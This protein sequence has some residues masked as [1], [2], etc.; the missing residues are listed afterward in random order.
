MFTVLSATRNKQL[1]ALDVSGLVI[2]ILLTPYRAIHL[3]KTHSENNRP[4]STKLYPWK[5]SAHIQRHTVWEATYPEMQC[6]TAGFHRNVSIIQGSYN[7]LQRGIE[8]EAPVSDR[9]AI[10]R[11]MRKTIT[12]ARFEIIWF[13]NYF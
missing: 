5:I 12:Y 6:K 8:V 1:V 13:P 3:R 2:W 7:T 11:D 9:T 4:V 10:F